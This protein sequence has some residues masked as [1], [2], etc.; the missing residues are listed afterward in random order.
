MRH[1]DS[2]EKT[3]LRDEQAR[4]VEWFDNR[5]QVLAAAGS[6]K[7][8]VMVARAAFGGNIVGSHSERLIRAP[9][10]PRGIVVTREC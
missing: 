4:A 2:I 3:T 9:S 7:T 5:V 8:S 10:G 6:G 1:H